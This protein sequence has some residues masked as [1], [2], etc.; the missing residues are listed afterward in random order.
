MSLQERIPEVELVQKRRWLKWLL[1]VVT[2]LVLGAWGYFEV[3]KRAWNRYNE[4][5]IRTEGSL[6]VGDLAPD[7][8]LAS[9]DGSGM[10]RVSDFYREK[11]LVLVFGSYT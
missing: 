5:D 6:A 7:L 8:E 11:P 3:L 2:V 10:K 1:A 9:V 4:D